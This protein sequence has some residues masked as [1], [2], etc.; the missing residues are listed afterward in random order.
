M[1]PLPNKI[2]P[3]RD[4]KVGGSSGEAICDAVR[5]SGATDIHVGRGSVHVGPAPVAGLYISTPRALHTAASDCLL[6]V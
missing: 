5:T 2:S 6:F 3:K 4:R 1:S